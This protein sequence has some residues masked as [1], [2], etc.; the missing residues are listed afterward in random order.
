MN[1]LTIG[2][3]PFTFLYFFIL[4]VVYADFTINNSI[5]AASSNNVQ[6][7]ESVQLIDAENDT[8]LREIDIT[9]DSVKINLAELP[10]VGLNINAIKRGGN[11]GSM[12]FELFDVNRGTTYTRKENIAPYALF[13]D[14]NGDYS[15]WS[16]KPNVG[17]IFILKVTPYSQRNLGGEQGAQ[18]SVVLSFVEEIIPTNEPP[19]VNVNGDF[20]IIL[21]R[22]ELSIYGYT[23]DND[24]YIVDSVWTKEKGPD[25]LLE[26][27]RGRLVIYPKIAG[28]YV[29]RLTAT[30]DQGASS[31]D[32]ATIIVKNPEKLDPI[33]TTSNRRI[34]STQDTVILTAFGNDP[35]GGE[36]SYLWELLDGPNTPTMEGVQ[37]NQLLLSDL[38]V[39]E[40]KFQV[41]VTDDEGAVSSTEAKLTVRDP[42]K[43]DPVVTTFQRGAQSTQDTV[44]MVAFGSDPDGGDVSFLW[45]LLDGPN[46]PT[47]EGVQSNQL[48]LSDLQVG[49]YNFQVTV[50]DDEDMSA[51]SIASLNVFLVDSV[52]EGN[53]TLTTQ[54]EVNA[55]KC[56][57]ITGLLKI[58]GESITDLSALKYLKKIGDGLHLD[59]SNISDVE[60]LSGLNYFS[61][62]LYIRNNKLLKS[63]QG[64]RNINKG[65]LINGLYVT[66]SANLIDL[67]GLEFIKSSGMVYIGEN[68]LLENIDGLI[69]LTSIR[70]NTFIVENPNLKSIEGLQNAVYTGTRSNPSINIYGNTSLNICCA[71]LG[72]LTS[73]GINGYTYNNAPGCNTIAEISENCT[74]EQVSFRIEAEDNYSVLTD[75][76]NYDIG[77]NL[78]GSMSNQYAVTMYDKGDQINITF[79]VP[80]QDEYIIKVNL[81]SGHRFNATAYW[82]SGYLFQLNGED[83]IL[84]G[85]ESSVSPFQ[86]NHGGSYFGNMESEK[87]FLSAGQHN[88]AITANSQWSL[89]DYI[90]II[91]EGQTTVNLAP[92]KINLSNSVVNTYYKGL[93]ATISAEDPDP[94]DTHTFELTYNEGNFKIEGNSLI[95]T[96]EYEAPRLL[97]VGIKAIDSR[98]NQYEVIFT[99]NMQENPDFCSG[100]VILSSQEEV[101]N[102][103]CSFISGSL[104]I[105][106]NDIT[107]LSALKSLKRIDGSLSISET[108]LANLDGLEGLE[109]FSRGLEILQNNN[110]EDISALSNIKEDIGLR[111]LRIKSNQLL[112]NLDGLESIVDIF[113][114]QIE[115]NASL[116]D[117]DGL[118][119][120]IS[121]QHNSRILGN[122]KLTNL[123]G[124][125]NAVHTGTASTPSLLIAENTSLSVCCG[126]LGFMSSSEV[127]PFIRDNAP[128]CNSKEEIV[129]TCNTEP[130]SFKLEAEDNFTV[131][132]DVGNYKI[133]ANGNGAMSNGEAVT[134]YDKGDKI[135]ISFEV[136]EQGEYVIKVNLRS[137]NRFDPDAYWPSGYLF[138]LDGNDITLVGDVSSISDFLSS[139]G[140]SYFGTMESEKVNINAGTHNLSITTNSQWAVVDYIEIIGEGQATVNL[141]PT[142]INLSSVETYTIYKGA[143]AAISVE[144]PDTNDTHILELVYSNETQ[145]SG[146]FKIEGDSLLLNQEYYSPT[147]LSIR[148]RATDSKGNKIDQDFLIDVQE[149][150]T[151][152]SGDITLT[153]QEEVDNFNCSYITR[154]LVIS[155]DDITDLT[156]LEGLDRILLHL[157][158]KDN[159]LLEN[160]KGLE[161]LQFCFNVVIDNNASL[162]STEGFE[163]NHI[164]GNIYIRNNSQL[165]DISNINFPIYSDALTLELYGNR[166]LETCCIAKRFIGSNLTVYD[167]AP[168]CNSKEEIEMTCNEQPS[169]TARFEAEDHFSVLTDIGS[170]KIGTNGNGSMSN[171]EAVTMYDNGDKIRLDFTVPASGNY[172]LAVNLRSG[173][174]SNSVAYWPSGYSFKLNG[175]SLIMQGNNASISDLLSSY[176]GSYFG[177]M[178]STIFL[179]EGSHYLEVEANSSWAVVDY[180][181]ITSISAS[182]R[183]ANLS[184]P[185]Q[186]E[187]IVNIDDLT[188]Y[189]NPTSGLLNISFS[190]N[191]NLPTEIKLLDSTGRII[192]RR[193]YEGK[194]YDTINLSDYA[195]GYYIITFQFGNKVLHK[196]IILN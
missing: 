35:D 186:E 57:E 43:F 170:Y 67:E 129:T 88:L 177:N 81:R 134:M 73:Q 159:P 117:V 128:G 194:I 142:K 104:S 47:M 46:E 5:E 90:E 136:P 161:N 99:L 68:T 74:A 118:I 106:G 44:I 147:T 153:S 109:Y 33:V 18:F 96:Q 192:E 76:G 55:C 100:D 146:F 121:L 24:G 154:S 157:V 86:A 4:N 110:L 111:D 130:I 135:N 185:Q 160:L 91:G 175:T 38:Q 62:V 15:S 56:T 1:K 17:D 39:G 101:N 124:L 172:Q 61:G 9:L 125:K 37:S 93:V 40:Y 193:S 94:N 98:G 13:G 79:E 183:L 133:S 126:A 25:I 123:N 45:E 116:E 139:Y 131:L 127:V 8:L 49:D 149:N 12:G 105:R 103:T 83:I 184:Q 113:M 173:H 178:E 165:V 115:D 143:V 3:W 141:P 10:T 163:P 19:I 145:H 48:L 72:I 187:D 158:I 144:D 191:D 77:V 75:V 51:T 174:R 66:N 190:G 20:T 92:T 137:G 78:N 150:P 36:V 42:E 179:S 140:G 188:V 152:C 14:S 114:L 180:L 23:S 34:E 64:F 53:I 80:E 65:T 84:E 189:P 112:K 59:D 22:N 155:G 132:T 195:K 167:N 30:D 7:I 162:K 69:N 138:Q 60:G 176:G 54:A 58:Q 122:P 148:I 29:F 95:L 119:N 28:E 89:V 166:S 41:T 82:P 2:F 52:C 50:T 87:V 85:N 120:L 164:D 181:E 97:K 196:K 71:A 168:G 171:G 32:E 70:D 102:L 107:D 31:Y 182:S 27:Q 63:L 16:P 11:V 108:N 151:F 156:P 21:P 169:V 6:V 26:V